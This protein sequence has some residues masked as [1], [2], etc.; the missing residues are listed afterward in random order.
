M[1]ETPF[2][3][4]Y[5]RMLTRRFKLPDGRED[6]YTIKDEGQPVCIFAMTIDGQVILAEQYRPGPERILLEM[7]GGNM[8][9]NESPES[10]AARELL[11]ETGYAGEL[12][13]VG[14][15]LDCAYSTLLRHAFVAT[16]CI[17]LQEPSLDED[18]F[19]EIRT[20]SVQDFRQHLRS[21][22]LTD[23]EIGYLGLDALGLLSQ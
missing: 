4:G 22:Q 15:V 5:R 17:K 3:A 16:N 18:E 20:M 11:E 21:G 7:P 6:E 10:A 14:T 23:V 1:S 2:K 13:H 9:K 19:I 12:R 8:E